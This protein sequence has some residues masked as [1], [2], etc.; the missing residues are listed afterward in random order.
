MFS[1]LY[2][3]GSLLVVNKPSGML[4][5]P[6]K[7]EKRLSL[8]E[9]LNKKLNQE[10]KP[11]RVHPCH[12]IDKDAS[13]I[14]VFAK[15]K[16]NQS[17]IMKQFQKHQVKKKYIAF[18]KGRFTDKKSTLIDY[19]KAI[20][21]KNPKKSILHYRVLQEKK[22][23]SVLEVEPVTGRMHQIRMQFAK[24]GHPLLGER[25][26]AFGKDFDVKFRRLALHAQKISLFHPQTKSIISFTAPLPEDMNNFLISHR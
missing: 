3:D 4:V 24:I 21:K 20:E 25:R 15:G 18:V 7:E 17:I 2:E 22:T 13:G 23:W 6:A 12:R 10:N 5:I 8:L 26:Y 14:V 1:I 19:I 9:L 11:Y 16:Q